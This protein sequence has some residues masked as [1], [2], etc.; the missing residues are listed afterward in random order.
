MGFLWSNARYLGH[1]RLTSIAN[2]DLYSFEQLDSSME[3]LKI[4][5]RPRSAN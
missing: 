4:R 3:D 1:F 2:Q 5:M